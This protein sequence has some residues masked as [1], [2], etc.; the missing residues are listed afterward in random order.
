MPGTPKIVL[1]RQRYAT[2]RIRA[3]GQKRTIQGDLYHYILGHGWLPLLGIV[4]SLFLATNTLFA[5]AYL[6]EPESI[7]HARPGSFV[8]A[9]FFSV[10]TMATI[11][12]GEMAPATFYAHVLVTVEALAG[13]LGF[14][15]VA[16]ITFSKF[17]RPTAQVLFAEKAVITPRNGV[18]H[19]MFRMANWRHNEIA[20]AELRVVLLSNETTA[21]GDTMRR[22]VDLPLVRSRS[23]L[24]ALTWT[25]MHKIDGTSPFFG[26][27]ALATLASRDTE[28][29]LSL[30]GHDERLG[31]TIHARHRYRIDDV[32]PRARFVD[33][34][35]TLPDGTRVIDYRKFHEVV[36]IKG[37]GD[38]TQ[39]KAPT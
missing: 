19:L 14:A 4:V 22:Q 24:F 39:D 38:Q 17:S 30:R 37:H 6:L 25:A 3:I 11:G 12:Y 9:F 31:Q 13:V 2:P 10:E 7:A 29:F 1:R 36:A 27:L 15:L 33:V 34:L 20:E 5:A 28:L 21:E 26:K 18:P 35:S 32:V 16:G 8:D 23:A